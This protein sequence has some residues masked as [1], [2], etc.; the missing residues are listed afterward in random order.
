M[1]GAAGVVTASLYSGRPDPEWAIDEAPL[2]AL[3]RIW[4]GL[5]ARATGPPQPPPLGYRGCSLR[6]ASGDLWLAY[7]GVATHRRGNRPPE[8]RSDRG[9]R[10]EKA[11]LETA[12]A[13]VLPA[14]LLRL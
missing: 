11:L 5:A 4:D 9:R 3:R 12:P 7:G 10:F 8:H 2:E 13:G 1:S 14:E 6:C